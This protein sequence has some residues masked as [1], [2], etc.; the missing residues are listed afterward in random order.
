MDGQMKDPTFRLS[1][2]SID[3]PRCGGKAA[4]RRPVMKAVG[5]SWQLEYECANGHR[6]T[7]LTKP[8]I[9]TVLDHAG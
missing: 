4:W 7:V 8:K 1:S 6:L 5:M 3:C 2:P 9:G